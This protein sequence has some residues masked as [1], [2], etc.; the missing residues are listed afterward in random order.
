MAIVG[1]GN[2]G[3]DLMY[4]LMRSKTLEARFMIGRNRASVGLNRARAEGLQVS[5]QGIEWLLDRP[6]HPRLVFEATSAAVHA[7]H[8]PRYADAGITAIDLTPAAYGKPVIPAVNLEQHL[9]ESNISTVSCAGQVAVPIVYAIACFATVTEATVVVT[10]A[11]PSAGPGT[12][13]NLEAISTA[14]CRAIEALAPAGRATLALAVDDTEPPTPMRVVVSCVTDP[15]S[16]ADISA[17]VATIVADVARYVPGYRLTRPLHVQGL[18]GGRQ[19]VT[20]ALEV[21]GAGDYLP[22]YAGNLDIITAAA[23]EIGEVITEQAAGSM[24]PVER[25]TQSS[26]RD[27]ALHPPAMGP[28]GRD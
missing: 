8:A 24:T 14:T 2:V 10:I 6:D 17:S 18:P 20:V 25:L 1:P 5:A 7:A 23:V 19:R 12:L 27:S 3:T 9:G 4:K 28:A 13:G 16:G 21:E 26:A 15:S 11:A 22:R